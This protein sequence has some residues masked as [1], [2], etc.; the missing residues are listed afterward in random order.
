MS[1]KKLFQSTEKNRNYLSDTTQQ[2][3]FKSIESADNLEQIIVC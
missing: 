2:E 3:A 1:I